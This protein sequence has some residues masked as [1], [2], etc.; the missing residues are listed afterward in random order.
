LL[1]SAG[2]RVRIQPEEFGQNAIASLSQLD[3]LQPGKQAALLFI[4]QAVEKQ[5]GRF[6]FIGRYLE[7]GSIGHQRNRLRGLSGA[8]LIP[9]LPA[10]SRSV[11]EP[12]SHQRAPQT[13]GTHQIVEG[14]L[15]F[16]M[17]SVSE[18]VGEAAAGRQIDE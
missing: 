17:E 9:G 11:Q 18:F 1:A 3:G 13:L 14:I 5:N 6:E 15:D 7:R 10:V 12:T 16:H 4:E 8:Q 2:N